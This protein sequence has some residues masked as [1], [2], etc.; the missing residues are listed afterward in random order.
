MRRE[1]TK[2]LPH[3]ST[4]EEDTGDDD[5]VGGLGKFSHGHSCLA[6]Q[7]WVR[8]VIS[9]GSFGVHC[10][11]AA[12]AAHKKCMSLSSHRVRHLRQNRT[13]KS[14]LEYLRRHEL[15]ETMK[16]KQQHTSTQ[17]RVIHGVQVPL[18]LPMSGNQHVNM[19]VNLHETRHQRSFLHPEV[20]DTCPHV[21]MCI[22]SF[23]KA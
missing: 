17:R 11:E 3:H 19:C 4:T 10:T 16:E 2:Q 13:Q 6:H 14:M 9:A 12:E 5:D 23:Y 20:R 18:I 8:Q 15:F 21:L 1:W 22:S 7:H